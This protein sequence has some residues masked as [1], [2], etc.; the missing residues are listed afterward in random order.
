M[1]RIS[2]FVAL[3][4]TSIVID[5]ILAI[6]VMLLW[7][8]VLVHAVSGVQELTYLESWGMIVLTEILFKVRTSPKKSE[9]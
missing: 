8:G 2:D 9:A 6:P 4:I 1:E 7:N 3:L 5:L